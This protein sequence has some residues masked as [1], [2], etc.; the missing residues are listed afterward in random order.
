MPPRILNLARYGGL[1]VHPSL[2]PDLKGPAPIQHAILRGRSHTGVSVQT[3]HPSQFDGGVVLAQTPAPG[4]P[5][6]AGMSADA[7]TQRLGEEGASMLVD[8]LKKGAFVP[9][10]RDVGWYKEATA[11]VDHAGKMAKTDQQV[12]FSTTTLDRLVKVRRAIGEPW[13]TL[14]NGERLILNEFSVVDRDAL[15]GEGTEALWVGKL[16]APAGGAS[17]EEEALLARMACG[18]VVRIE[19]SSI[20]GRPVGGGNQRVVG[21]LK[22][23]KT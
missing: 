4:I 16:V 22:G 2:L 17:K 11:P 18:G 3:L 6:P 21:M 10:L 13:C 1:N 9:P 5:I 15:R 7:L 12:E 8:V 19:R 14:G 23:K 20:S